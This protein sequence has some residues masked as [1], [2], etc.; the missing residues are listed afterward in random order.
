MTMEIET[1]ITRLF[2]KMSV[3]QHDSGR[4]LNCIITDM[5]IPAGSSARIYVLKPSGAEIYNDCVITGNTVEVALTTQMLAEVGS[6]YCQIEITKT[7]KTVTSCEFS[8]D[9]NRSL[10]SDGAIE[11][12]NEFTAL[13]E[14]LSDV[15]ELRE[16]GK[17]LKNPTFVQAAMRENINSGEDLN[18]ILGKIKKWFADLGTAAFCSVVNNATTTIANTVLDGRMGK[19]LMDK[20]NELN[21]NMQ[22]HILYGF[23]PNVFGCS[24]SVEG[25]SA[26]FTCYAFAQRISYNFYSIDIK[27][28]VST[29]APESFFTYGI[30]SEIICRA[31]FNALPKHTYGGQCTI[32]NTD[33]TINSYM[34]GY[35]AFLAIEH[36]NL[37]MPARYYTPSGDGG[38]WGLDSLDGKFIYGYFFVSM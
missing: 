38:G 10:V 8:L 16:L 25:V 29:R 36:N 26:I 23:I 15:E 9:V 3:I 13:E 12:T 21:T 22:P 20:I 32:Y 4:I 37:L 17:E 11:S 35:G 5:T 34:N 33:Y 28:Q 2:K 7:Q 1:G 30:S 24:V 14:A 6:A 27:V 18:T 19:I 31:L